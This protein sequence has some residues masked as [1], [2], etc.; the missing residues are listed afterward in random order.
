MKFESQGQAWLGKEIASHVHQDLCSLT[1]VLEEPS[2]N[3]GGESRVLQDSVRGTTVV[4]E[5]EGREGSNT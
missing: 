1:P 4:E 2:W 3:V 5:T